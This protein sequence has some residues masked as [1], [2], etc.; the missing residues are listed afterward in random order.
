MSAM[1]AWTMAAICLIV[2]DY[3]V[4][5]R[6]RVVRRWGGV[7][8]TRMKLEIPWNNTECW[9]AKQPTGCNSRSQAQMWKRRFIDRNDANAIRFPYL[10]IER[11]S[12][13]H[14]EW[15][16]LRWPHRFGWT[17]SCGSPVVHHIEM[18]I[19]QTVF[20]LRMHR[21]TF[22][23]QWLHRCDQSHIGIKTASASY[24]N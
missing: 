6:C 13:L 3:L 21:E 4:Q 14:F 5:F 18:S 11:S 15:Q 8:Y 23:R 24:R 20:S 2:V 16:W 1:H 22:L 9:V 17:M 19:W 12:K 7:Q 10:R